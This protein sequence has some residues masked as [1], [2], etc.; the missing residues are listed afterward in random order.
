VDLVGPE[1]FL[2]RASRC[3]IAHRAEYLLG[4]H[5]DIGELET[6]M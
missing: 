3:L 1:R 5:T 6:P 4:I 2:T